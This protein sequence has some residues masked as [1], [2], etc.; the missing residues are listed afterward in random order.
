MSVSYAS[1]WVQI[2]NRALG[3]LGTTTISSLASTGENDQ[4]VK[5]CN[6]FLGDAIEDVLGQYDWNCCTKRSV[7]AR[8]SAA[9]TFGFLY[10]YPLPVN[11]LRLVSI[12]VGVESYKIENSHIL[13]DSDT[14][15]LVYIERPTD[16]N[17]LPPLVRKAISA[18]LAFLL[19]TPLTSSEALSSR[20]IA[21]Y[22]DALSKAKDAD[23]MS[24]YNPDAA[25]VPFYDEDRG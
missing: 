17:A 13:T 25:G 7:L 9:P 10:Q 1:T 14:V 11:F 3:R 4:N 20:I 19:S 18:A 15:E 24:S 5:Y 21:E 23:A 16:P 12:N 8:L 6:L 2:C 22:S